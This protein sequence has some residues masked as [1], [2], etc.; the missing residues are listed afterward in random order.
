MNCDSAP[1]SFDKL[2]VAM[3]T[4]PHLLRRCFERLKA[5]YSKRAD[6][7]YRKT[8]WRAKRARPRSFGASK[9]QLLF[10]GYAE[11]A[12]GIGESFR[13]LLTALDAAGLSFSIYPFSR[14]VETRRIRA[15]LGAP[16]PDRTATYL[17]RSPIWPSIAFRIVS[18]SSASSSPEVVTRS[19]VRGYPRRSVGWCNHFRRTGR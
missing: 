7:V 1:W 14:N 9:L 8:L 6:R 2:G 11:A 4:F 18:R 17:L 5:S 16:I 10:V 19:L 3:K 13:Y 15:L 12:L